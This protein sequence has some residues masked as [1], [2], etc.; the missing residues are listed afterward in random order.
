MST[1]SS[2]RGNRGE[3]NELNKTSSQFIFT[4]II[5]GLI[6]LV[7]VAVIFVCIYGYRYKRQ[8]ESATFTTSSV[9]H[10]AFR[11]SATVTDTHMLTYTQAAGPTD[12][13]ETL[14]PS[15][16]GLAVP[17]FREVP[18]NSFALVRQVA[19]GGG[20]QIY[21]AQAMSAVTSEFGTELIV[22]VVGNSQKEVSRVMMEAVKQ[23]ISIL[24]LMSNQ[25]H[26]P[27]FV[28]Y[29]ERPVSILM[30]Y[31]ECGSLETYLKMPLRRNHIVSLT[32]D[33]SQ[34][35]LALHS[36]H[37]A[38]CDL[39]PANVLLDRADDGRL[40]A[41]LTDFGIARITSDVILAAKNFNLVY[42]RGLSWRYAAPEM[43]YRFRGVMIHEDELTMKAGD[44]YSFAMVTYELLNRHAPW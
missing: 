39:K 3:L 43:I 13:A 6:F 37:I 27:R 18:S 42:L 31:Y 11:S 29:C 10:D 36:S 35:L 25:R 12:T 26:F 24:Q 38:H 28:G 44:V 9:L 8:K 41:I 17:G 32:S 23:E 15:S 19:K 7:A 16:M 2:I 34:A 21:I 1:A 40:V 4:I 22:K 33:I 14:V 20:G 30:K 5:A